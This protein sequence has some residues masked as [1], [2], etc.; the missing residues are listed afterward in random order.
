MTYLLQLNMDSKRETDNYITWQLKVVM[1]T[2]INVPFLCCNISLSSVYG[3]YI[4]LLIWYA[5]WCSAYENFLKR[6]QPLTKQLMLQVCNESRL[7]LSFHNK[8]MVVVLTL[9]AITKYNWSE[10]WMI[11]FIPF[12]RLSFSCWLWR[13]IIPYAEFW[14]RAHDGCDRSAKNVYTSMAP[15]HTFVFV[16]GPFWSTF[17]FVFAF[18]IMIMFYTLLNLLF[19]YCQC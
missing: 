9:L 16:R 5:R 2:F 8:S 10:S 14:P 17:G 18:W 19:W 1:I 7:K 13:W 6:G 3:V 12:V 15:D 4:L 11:C